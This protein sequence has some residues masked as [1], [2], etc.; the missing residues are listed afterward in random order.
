MFFSNDDN[1]RR[2]LEW[3]SRAYFRRTATYPACGEATLQYLYWNDKM[4]PRI[5]QVYGQAP[6]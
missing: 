6:I 3:Y 2:G 1:Y 4:V 5:Q